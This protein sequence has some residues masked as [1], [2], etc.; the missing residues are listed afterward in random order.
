MITLSLAQHMVAKTEDEKKLSDQILKLYE[1]KK[2]L[3]IS[4]SAIAMSADELWEGGPS[5]DYIQTFNFIN[6]LNK[7][8]AGRC[9]DVKVVIAIEEQSSWLMSMYKAA[10]K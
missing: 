6:R 1:K 5:A 9:G 4:C 7:N 10:F 8:L 3:I 2:K